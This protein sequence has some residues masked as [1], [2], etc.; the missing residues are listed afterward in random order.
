[1]TACLLVA[2]GFQVCAAAAYLLTGSKG[3][4]VG[5]PA[6]ASPRTAGTGAVGDTT[7]RSE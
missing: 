6:E 7:A 5:T 1:V 2:A 3:R 4:G